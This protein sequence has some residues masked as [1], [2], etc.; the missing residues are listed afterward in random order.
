MN[1]ARVGEETAEPRDCVL[2][3]IAA[4]REPASFVYEDG[5]VVAI[6]SLDQPTRLKV[7]VFPRAHVETIFDLSDTMAGDVFRAASRIARGI[8]SASGWGDMN[9]VQSNGAAAGQEVPHFHLHLV[10]R[11]E[12][13]EILLQW[14]ARRV[15]REELDAMAAEIRSGMGTG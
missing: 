2:C 4:G 3:A 15:P 13:D 9:L 11:S 14:P 7:L 10:P 1:G 12:G 8:R 5:E 6:L